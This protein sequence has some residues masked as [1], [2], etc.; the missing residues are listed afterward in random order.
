MSF[1]LT[2]QLLITR[3][4]IEKLHAKFEILHLKCCPISKKTFSRPSSTQQ[5]TIAMDNFM[6]LLF[7]RVNF[8][9]IH[10]RSFNKMITIYQ[11]DKI[12]LQSLINQLK[13]SMF[14]LLLHLCIDLGFWLKLISFCYTTFGTYI[15][16]C[17]KIIK[18][19]G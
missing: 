15:R 12:I 19:Y 13:A 5:H 2:R 14:F 10:L 1:V 4:F 16:P 3:V 17:F 9:S 11:F 7:I 8:Y 18:Q 6:L